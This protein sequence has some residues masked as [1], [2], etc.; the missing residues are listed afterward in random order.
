MKANSFV[1]NAWYVAGMSS[2]FETR[3]LRGMTIAKRP[4]VIWRADDGSVVAFDDRCVHKRMPLSCGKLLEN[5]TLEC[6]YHGFTYD[7]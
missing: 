7:G 2:E 5:G 3:Q 1:Q 6:A 4:I